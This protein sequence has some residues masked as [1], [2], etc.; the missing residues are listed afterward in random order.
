MPGLVLANQ[1][2]PCL[3][4]FP[5]AFSGIQPFETFS[6]GSEIPSRA[7]EIDRGRRVS[8]QEVLGS[9]SREAGTPTDLSCGRGP[10]SRS[11]V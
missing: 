11:S 3:P 10:A 6:S 1:P 2:F 5:E 9:P 7:K 4:S 8:P